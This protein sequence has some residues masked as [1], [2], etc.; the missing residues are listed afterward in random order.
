[1]TGKAESQ[2][3]WPMDPP[4]A[5]A[6]WPSRACAQLCGAN[7]YGLRR[8]APSTRPANR[9]AAAP[10]ATVISSR[11]LTPARICSR[12]DADVA[13]PVAADLAAMRRCGG[14]SL[15]TPR[16]SAPRRQ[17]QRS[18]STS[19]WACASR[20]PVPPGPGPGQIPLSVRLL[21]VAPLVRARSGSP[22]CASDDLHAGRVPRPRGR[23]FSLVVLSFQ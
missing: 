23:L 16:R 1:M 12:H 22:R 7:S 15:H 18:T 4:P 20:P 8:F 19:G 2:A 14:R 10:L 13:F 3:Q 11:R 17:R 6:R 5:L 21:P 9:Q